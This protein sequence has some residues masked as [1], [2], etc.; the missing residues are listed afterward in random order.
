M[1]VFALGGYGKT[2]FAAIK[3]LAKSNLI[4]EIAIVGRNIEHAEKAV[5]EIGE[6]AIAV[7]ADGMDTQKLIA[8]SQDYDIIMN[9]ASNQAMLP[10]I[11]AAIH[12]KIHYCDVSW[13]EILDQ[14]AQ[15]TSKAKAAGITAIV[16]NGIS[17]CISNLMGVHIARHLDE[18][19]QLQIGRADIFNFETGNELT[20]QQWQ[21]DPKE[22]LEGLD[23][24]KP[25]ISW[26]LQRLQEN[27]VRLIREHQNGHWVAIDPVK[28]GLDIPLPG[29]GT[30]KSYPY[31]SGDDFFGMLPKDLAKVSPVEIWFSPFPPQL[32]A[33]LREQALRVL[34][35]NI[36]Y[37]DAINTFFD[38]IESNPDRWLTLPD[39]FNPNTKM[40]VR[41]LGQK[42]DRTARSTCWFTTHLWNAGGY[43]LTSVALVAA[44]HK[45]LR[46]EIREHGVFTAEK[47][48]DPQSFFDE[49][50]AF[51][52]DPPPH[53]KLINESFE[54]LQ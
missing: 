4:T 19:E 42:D 8:L 54:W 40:W 13:G 48:F 44:V 28:N 3:L 38:T 20:P 41:A 1:K 35:E 23:A 53:G 30:I 24:F 12:N 33:V 34:E 7:Q 51:L 18:V 45:I 21:N 39:N 31:C 11:Q 5:V 43:F 9:A 15:L 32:H 17:P 29:G 37:E 22:S 47:A 16:A 10:S 36:N 25:F 2:G 52:P 14:A 27:G 50:V 6:K 26:M 46:G 49:V